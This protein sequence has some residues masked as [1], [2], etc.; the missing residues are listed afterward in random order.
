MDTVF[1]FMSSIAGGE[2]STMMV[3]AFVFLSAAALAFGLINVMT[4]DFYGSIIQYDATR[5]GLGL[6]GAWMLAG[7]VVMYKMCNFRI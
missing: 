6:A 2:S 7:N 1:E 5:W 4:P 3:S